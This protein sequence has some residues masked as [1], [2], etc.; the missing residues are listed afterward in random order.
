MLLIKYFKDGLE[1]EERIEDDDYYS[2]AARIPEVT[3]AKNATKVVASGKWQERIRTHF[4]NLPLMETGVYSPTIAWYG[5]DAKFI[6][7][8]IADV[9]SAYFQ[10]WKGDKTTPDVTSKMKLDC[11][12][13][14]VLDHT[15][16]DLTRIVKIHEALDG[17]F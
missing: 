4:S 8:N 5:D 12:R 17:I 10:F 7:G 14:L 13:S 1:Y 11:I 16:S 15:M 6:A 2:F 3:Q 9:C